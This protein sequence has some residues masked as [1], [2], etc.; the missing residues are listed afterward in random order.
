MLMISHLL[1]DSPAATKLM[2][3]TKII[4]ALPC[5]FITVEIN[6]FLVNPDMRG[7]GR[8]SADRIHAHKYKHSGG[9]FFFLLGRSL[10]HS[11]MSL[12]WWKKKRVSIEGLSL[13]HYRSQEEKR[14]EDKERGSKRWG[15][16]ETEIASGHFSNIYQG[17]NIWFTASPRVFP[18]SNT[19]SSSCPGTALTD[20]ASQNQSHSCLM[21]GSSTGMLEDRVSAV[22]NCTDKLTDRERGQTN[23]EHRAKITVKM[24][25]DRWRGCK[26]W[27][28]H[29]L[30]FC[31]TCKIKAKV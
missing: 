28:R 10:C 2:S 14:K 27:T 7:S 5:G 1:E 29:S 13:Y 11:G 20:K 30:E 4:L 16:G 24:T 18:T 3:A 23:R 17:S 9:L 19:T 25:T 21:R 26:G 15:E 6:S 12:Y 22:N 8:L 31:Q